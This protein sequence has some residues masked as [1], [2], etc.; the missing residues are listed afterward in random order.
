MW[1]LFAVCGAL[2]AEAG[3]HMAG[4][5]VSRV[6]AHQGHGGTHVEDKLLF[7]VQPLGLGHPVC[8]QSGR[9]SRV[10]RRPEFLTA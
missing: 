1:A 5:W 7:E 3:R 10:N 9:Y 8:A 4:R 6:Q 2:R